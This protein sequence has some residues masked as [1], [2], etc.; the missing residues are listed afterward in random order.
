MR[1]AGFVKRSSPA[2]A[3]AAWIHRQIAFVKRGYFGPAST[4]A[5]LEKLAAPFPRCGPAPS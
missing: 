5:V 1:R 3:F 4:K 2:N